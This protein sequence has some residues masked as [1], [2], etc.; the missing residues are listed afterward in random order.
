MLLPVLVMAVS[1]S[2]S[3]TAE[4]ATPPEFHFGLASSSPA[5]GSSVGSPSALRLTFTEV[6]AE[7]TVSIRVLESE[8]AGVHVMDAVQD[9]EDA[10]SFVAAVHGVFPAGTYTVS[11]RG[12]GADG[13]VVRDS[14]QFTVQAP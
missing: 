8:G 13:H 5:A 2:T 10:R 14:F 6:P 3:P 9:T 1:A 7:G 4:S 11:W 12:M